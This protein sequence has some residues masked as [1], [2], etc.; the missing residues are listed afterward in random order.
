MF[1]V[2]M[3][4]LWT[5]HI[6]TPA[7]RAEGIPAEFTPRIFVH[8]RPEV[9]TNPSF[10]AGEDD[11]LFSVSQG[12]RAGLSVQKGSFEGVVDFQG[13]Q[14]WGARAGSTSPEGT[15]YVQQ[16]YIQVDLG[17]HWLRFGR[18]ELHL[19]NGWHMSRAPWN[20]AGRSFDG[21]RAH[22]EPGQ[23]EVDA[24]SV[25]LRAP[26]PEVPVPVGDTGQVRPEPSLGETHV[27]VFTGWSP[28]EDFSVGPIALARFA[29]PSELAGDQQVWWAT[30]GFR[31]RST[32]GETSVDMT[33][34]G[35]VGDDT[36]TPIRGYSAMLRARRGL[37]DLALKPG[38]GVIFEQNSGHACAADSAPDECATDT[39]R[40]VQTG[41]G[42]N[43]ALRGNADQ[44]RGTNLR[45]LGMELDATLWT[46]AGKRSLQTALQGHLFQLVDPEGLWLDATGSVQGRGYLPGNTDPNLAWEIDALMDLW[47]TKTAHI[48]AGV[49]V[50]QPIGA[51]AEM[52]GPD[53]MTYAFA[54]NRFLF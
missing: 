20:V 43:H 16:G 15:A 25:V 34:L 41:F 37:G 44:F 29:G 24:F 19:Q 3:P 11:G 45:D 46:G 52:T 50:V 13:T 8:L 10:V 42:R 54:R 48:D 36:G 7:A 18:Q 9:R 40:N 14:A 32:P 23:W 28:S 51:G 35:Q 30:P 31:L 22:F 6:A 21:V 2:A 33:L 53:A 12:L 38:V 39:I 1:A 5:A 47:V 26:S 4:L 27:G 17:D 49:C